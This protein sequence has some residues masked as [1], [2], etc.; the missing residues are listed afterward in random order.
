ME[1]YNEQTVDNL[2]EE[3]TSEKTANN[4]N[5]LK[6]NAP[7]S[8]AVLICGILSIVTCCCGSGFVGIAIAII[9]IILAAKSKKE[10]ELNHDLYDENSLGKVKTGKICAIIG[11]ILGIVV[12]IITIIAAHSNLGNFDISNITSEG[13]DQL[14]Y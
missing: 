11:L 5:G 6:M 12:F 3:T 13:W 7:K 10:Y 1:E 9:A 2:T 8:N 4:M 14:G